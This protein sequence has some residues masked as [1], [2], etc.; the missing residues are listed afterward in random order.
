MS[1]LFRNAIL[2]AALALPLLSAHGAA[3]TCSTSVT[4]VP[5]LDPAAT[6]AGLGDLSL[7]CAG[8]AAT[9]PL[10][11]VNFQSFFNVALLQDTAPVLTDGSSYYAG[12]FV[13][14]NA[15]A[16]LGIP[17]NPVASTFT[18]EQ[19]FVNPSLLAAGTQILELLSVSGELFLPVA[20]PLQLV[21]VVGAPTHSV[22]APATAWLF[23]AA[24]GILGWLR[25]TRAKH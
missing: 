16:F 6:S 11:T 18:I 24:L 17:V 3:L 4:T 7:A 23:V 5:V 22:P 2:L 19:I 9:D 10:P 13:G 15:I 21:G 12:T 25:R 8:G 1:R 20:D 14:G